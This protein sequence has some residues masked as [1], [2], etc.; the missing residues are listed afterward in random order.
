MEPNKPDKLADQIIEVL[1]LEQNK[2]D[3]IGNNA[4]KRIIEKFSLN[5]MLQ[6]TIAVYEGLIAAKQDFN[7]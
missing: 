3:L 4:R 2:K 7:N 5:Q 1:D 6:K